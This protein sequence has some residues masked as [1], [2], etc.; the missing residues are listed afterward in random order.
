VRE[1]IHQRRGLERNG[2]YL[3]PRD[4]APKPE[5]DIERLDSGTLAPD[6]FAQES[7]Q[8]IP[9][10]RA[11]DLFA[12]DDI[13]HSSV[14]TSG[15]ERK[16]LQIFTVDAAAAL[17][18]T[19]KRR[20]PSQTMTLDRAYR[21]ARVAF[22]PGLD[23]KPAAPFAAAGTQYLTPRCGFHSSAKT[24]CAL[25]PDDRR[26]I[27]AFHGLPWVR[28]SLKLEHFARAF[29]KINWPRAAVDNFAA[30]GVQ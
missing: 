13:T 8:Q 30:A 16:Q 29:V 6:G 20:S 7:A 3:R 11:A 14:R 22:R 23:C 19:C 27:C 1:D 5:D 9:V 21:R 25:A 26:L 2:A 18:Y 17:K 15:G 12:G 28:K 24:V 4:G 10:D